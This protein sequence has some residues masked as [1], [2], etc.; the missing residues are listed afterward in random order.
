MI[1]SD[2]NTSVQP[3]IKDLSRLKALGVNLVVAYVYVHQSTPESDDVHIAPQ[4]DTDKTLATLAQRAHALGM[5]VEFAPTIV[6][7]QGS[8]CSSHFYW[9]GLLKPTHPGAWWHNYN[10][11]IKHYVGLSDAV[12]AEILSIGSELNTMQKYTTQWIRL[13][14]WVQHHYPGLTTYMATGN[15]VF[16]EP[17]A[18]H[19]DIISASAY[20]SVSNEAIPNVGE[21]AYVWKHTYLPKLKTLFTKYHKRVL[22][23]EVGY[24]SILYAAYHP[25]TEY[26]TGTAASQTA[27]ANAYQALLRASTDEPWLRGVTWWHWDQLRNPV[28]DRGYSMR[29]KAAECVIAHYWG[30]QQDPTLGPPVD[31]TADACL[32]NHATEI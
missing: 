30:A 20:Y 4:T 3:A 25:A 27:Q 19:L 8:C 10:L 7:D 14:D 6:V 5:G 26:R 18:N 11:M 17:W 29:D 9:R 23:N 24:C 16:A 12:H 22:I 32:V 13:A 15:A 2:F 28:T 1:L 31:T 21:M